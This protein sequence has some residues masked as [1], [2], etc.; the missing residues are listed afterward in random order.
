MF[1]RAN[2]ESDL[3]GFEPDFTVINPCS[4]VN[5]DWKKHGLNSEVAVVFNVEKKC[6]AIFGT[7]YGGENKKGIFSM[8]NYWL[9]MEN[10]P[11]LPMHCASNVGKD[12]DSALFFGSLRHGQD[13]VVC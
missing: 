8:M 9:P 12:G 11:Q 4:Q 6:A 7:W 5:E 2:H 3:Q 13:N 1:I 10:P